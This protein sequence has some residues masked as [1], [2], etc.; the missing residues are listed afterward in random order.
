MPS[1][2]INDNGLTQYLGAMPDHM[3]TAAKH[4]VRKAA[5]NTHKQ[6]TRHSEL[7][8]RTGQLMRSIHLTVKGDTLDKISGAVFSEG[9]RYAR[10]QETGG[11]IKAKNAYRGV[12][13]GPYLN[14]P[15]SANKTA[16]GAMRQTAKQVFQGGG[17]IIRSRRGNYIVMS[18]MGVPMFVLKKQV[19]IP[20]RLGMQ[21][22][23]DDEVPLLM[24]R[25]QAAMDG[26]IA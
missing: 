13:G 25:L 7:H 6:I 18:S 17:S 9:N 19:V 5:S 14:I 4:E 8:R 11:V 24:N 10:I 21:K 3:F 26:V 12:Q 15:L 23:A 22:A 16:A 20:A 2:Q 1:V